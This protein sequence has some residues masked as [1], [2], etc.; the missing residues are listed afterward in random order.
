MQSA[1]SLEPHRRTRLNSE[2]LVLSQ[3]DYGS[4]VGDRRFLRSKIAA[5]SIDPV[6]KERPR[7]YISILV[8]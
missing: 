1:F 6:A 2:V 8:S 3:N 4:P 5:R 7:K